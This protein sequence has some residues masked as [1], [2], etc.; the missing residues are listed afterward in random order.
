MEGG[1]WANPKDSLGRLGNLREDQGN[2]HHPIK[3]PILYCFLCGGELN[4]MELLSFFCEDD[5]DPYISWL[6]K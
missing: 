1:N 5:R 3:N 4:S 6:M 2:H